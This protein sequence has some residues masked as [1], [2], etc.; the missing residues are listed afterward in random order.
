MQMHH[1]YHFLS[2]LTASGLG[3]A[4]CYSLSCQQILLYVQ[5][6]YRIRQFPKPLALR[7]QDFDS[8]IQNFHLNQLPIKQ[9]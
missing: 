8:Q 4:H 6:E 7:Q 1:S 5:L 2:S 9:L 3:K